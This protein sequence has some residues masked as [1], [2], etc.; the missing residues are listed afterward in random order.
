MQDIYCAKGHHFFSCASLKSCTLP[1]IQ[2]A[3]KSEDYLT[4]AILVAVKPC[5][6]LLCLSLVERQFKINKHDDTEK[7]NTWHRPTSNN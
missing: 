3:N 1:L 7:L 2:P 4:N 6:R 5:L